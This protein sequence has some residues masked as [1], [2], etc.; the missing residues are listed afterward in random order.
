MSR[1]KTSWTKVSTRPEAKND[2]AGEGQE[3]FNRPAGR[4]MFHSQIPFVAFIENLRLDK[5]DQY[6]RENF[7]TINYEM[8]TKIEIIATGNKLYVGL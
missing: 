3:R 1:G 5:Q 8:T 2:C 4:P 7:K 6:F